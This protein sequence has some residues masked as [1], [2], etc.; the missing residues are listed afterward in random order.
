[1]WLCCGVFASMNFFQIWENQRDQLLWCAVWKLLK[2]HWIPL[3]TSAKDKPVHQEGPVVSDSRAFCNQYR[4][5][6]LHD[7]NVLDSVW[8]YTESNF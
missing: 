5:D 3:I 8:A 7:R 1:M 4:Q 6:V 2:M